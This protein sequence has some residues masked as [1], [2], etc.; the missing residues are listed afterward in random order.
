MIVPA[1]YASWLCWVIPFMGSLFI[2]L[3]AK[4]RRRSIGWYAV[5]VTFLSAV[6]T[7]LLIPSILGVHGEPQVYSIP[8]MP[9]LDINLSVL[10]DPLSTLMANI[11]ACIGLLIMI[12][13]VNYMEK[14]KATPRYFFFMLLFVGGMVGLVMANNLLQMYFFWETVGLCSYALIGFWYTRPEA[15]KAGMKAFIVTRIGDIFL[16]LGI[17]L[18]YV[19]TGTLNFLEIRNLIAAGAVSVP[20][21]TVSLLMLIGAIGKSAQVPLQVWLPDAMEG[22]SPVSALIHGATMVKAGIYLVARIYILF[23]L[24]TPWLTTITYIGGITAFLA[25]TMALTSTDL[26]RVLAFSTISQLGM[27]M[28]ALGIGTEFGWFASQFHVISHALF[29][30]LLFLSAG[31]VMHITHT[32]DMKQLGGLRKEMP[33]TFIVSIIGAFSL[34]GIPPFSGFWSKDTI[35]EAIILGNSLP[36]FILIFGTSILTAIYSIRWISMVFLGKKSEH[37]EHHHIHDPKLTITVPLVLLAAASCITGFLKTPLEHFLEVPFEASFSGVVLA[38]LTSAIILAVA[39]PAAYF[40][41]FKK[42]DV[43]VVSARSFLK[44]P[45]YLLVSNGYY[46]DAVYNK[47]L[48]GVLGLSQV[49]YRVVEMSGLQQF[50]YAVATVASKIAHGTSQYIETFFDRFVYIVAG[51]AV[52]TARRTHVHLD[53]FLDRLCYILA[54]GTVETARVTHEYIDTFLDKLVYLFAGKTVEQ[55][56]KIKKI[57]RGHLPDFVL[58]A[59]LGFFLIVIL[60]LFT[61]LR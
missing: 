61:A 53:A 37:L 38:S 59:A 12:Y 35:F 28:A 13:S 9:A 8:W 45:L 1:E 44:N 21:L 51:G 18:L 34:A 31:V 23:S 25:A 20:M 41:Y 43:A 48:S 15:S 49:T 39:V 6:C 2:P 36:L 47:I 33:I 14:E 26:K 11:A 4:F 27:I 50:P 29:K 5:A 10:I 56:Q 19:N 60:L 52:E 55:G 57:H 24:V 30:S 7:V 40:L 58:A 17:L 3:V 32:L 42:R 22:P 16:L 46:F 54:G